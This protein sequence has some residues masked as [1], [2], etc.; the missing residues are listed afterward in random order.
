[1]TFLA[2]PRS[3]GPRARA[4]RAARCALAMAASRSPASGSGSRPG[5]VAAAIAGIAGGVVG[6]R[7]G[8]RSTRGR[9]SRRS[10]A[11]RRL[12]RRRDSA[13]CCSSSRRRTWF[14]GIRPRRPARRAPTW[15]CGIVPEPAFEY[16]ATS[17]AKLDPA[18]LRPDPAARARG[19]RRAPPGH[20]VPAHDPLPR[21]GHA[22][23][24][25][26]RLYGPLHRAAVGAAAARPPP[27]E[28][29]PAALPRLLG[30]RARRP[31]RAGPLM[32]DPTRRR[33]RRPGR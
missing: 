31:A 12:R 21:R 14:V 2:L 17:Y 1:M 22:T 4:R 9:P 20:A 19:H 30:R 13:S 18:V 26:E 29:Q 3:P 5:P 15:T 27:P 7:T 32:D 6:Q 23:C 10:S 33:D 8:D 28:R 25:D 11:R 24:I 16:T